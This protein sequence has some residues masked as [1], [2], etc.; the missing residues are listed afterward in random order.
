V[1]AA[2]E[3]FPAADSCR[4]RTTAAMSCGPRRESSSAARRAVVR[5]WSPSMSTSDHVAGRAGGAWRTDGVGATES[6]TSTPSGCSPQVGVGLAL[7]D[8]LSPVM[9]EDADDE[10]ASE[11]CS[12]VVWSPDWW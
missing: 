9:L 10:S 6:R 4:A 8:G 5:A 11:P 7:G 1:T 3:L 12:E 2:L